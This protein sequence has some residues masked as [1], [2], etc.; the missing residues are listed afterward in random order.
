MKRRP[1]P[2]LEIRC[3]VCLGL[4]LADDV[5]L[6]HTCTDCDHVLVVHDGVCDRLLH[7]RGT[8]AA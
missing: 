5:L 1:P 7:D 2:E 6:V 8:S 3:D 4:F